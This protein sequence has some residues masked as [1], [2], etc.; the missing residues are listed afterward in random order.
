[1][2]NNTHTFTLYSSFEGTFLTK[3]CKMQAPDPT[4]S[5]S[6][7]CFTLGSINKNLPS[8]LS[9]WSLRGYGMEVVGGGW[10]VLGWV[11]LLKKEN[12]RLKSFFKNVE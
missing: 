11:N 3:I 2:K 7:C 1:M 12:Q 5:F 8:C 6:S 4:R 10:G 9:F